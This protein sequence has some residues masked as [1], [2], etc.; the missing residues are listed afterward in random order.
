MSVN[1]RDYRILL[2]GFGMRF[3]FR[4]GALA[5]RSILTGEPYEELCSNALDDLLRAGLV[6]RVMWCA[7]GH[8]GYRLFVRALRDAS[9]PRE[10]FQRA[11]QPGPLRAFLGRL[12]HVMAY[13]RLHVVFCN[14]L[15]CACVWCRHRG[16]AF[17]GTSIT[18]LIRREATGARYTVA[19]RFRHRGTNRRWS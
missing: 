19:S 10:L 1:A 14:H 2:W 8:L 16:Q 11:Y 3:A 4:S 17:G 7:G 15:K 13:G 12:V 18:S 6:N 9:D 5:A